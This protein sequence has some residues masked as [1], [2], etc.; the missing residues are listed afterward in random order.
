M[1]KIWKIFFDDS[2]ELREQLF[3]N[4]IMLG[5]LAGVFA[6][7]E[8]YFL[9]NLKQVVLPFILLF[10]VLVI[11]TYLTI[12]YH[13]IEITAIIVGGI[14][15]GIMFPVMFFKSGGIH[16]G[17]TVWFV[18]S[19]FY[20]FIM[21]NGFKLWLFL[22]ITIVVDLTCYIVGYHHPAMIT[23]LDSEYTIYLDSAFG[24]FAVGITGSLMMR[25]QMNMFR[26]EREI[27]KQQTK[28]L[29]RAGDY[30]NAFFANVSHEIRTPLNSIIGL[31]DMILRE[32]V[33]EKVREYVKNSDVASH[34]LLSM[35]N[36]FLDISQLELKKMSIL[37][38]DYATKKLL[39]N[40]IDVM[41]VLAQEKNLEF[42][43]DIDEELPSILLGD[44]KRV[45][46]IL[47]NLLSN[48]IKYTNAGSVT[49]TVTKEWVPHRVTPGEEGSPEAFEKSKELDNVRL[50]I[51]VQDTGIGIRS[52]DLGHIY[53]SFKRLDGKT[54][55]A[56]QG[57]GLGLFITKQLVD[58]M[59]GNIWVD[60]IYTK[61]STFTVEIEQQVVDKTPIYEENVNRSKAKESY[62]QIFEAPEARV[63]IVDDDHISRLVTKNLLQ[64]TKMN[65]EVAKNGTECLNMAK[66]KYYH[67]IIMDHML[68]DMNGA[69]ILMELRNQENGLCRD[70]AVLLV[71]ANNLSEARRIFQENRFDGYLEKPFTSNALEEEVLKLLPKEIIELHNMAYTDTVKMVSAQKR[72]RICITSDCVCEIPEEWVEKYDIRLMYLYIKTE[73][74]RFADTLEIHSN[75][76]SDYLTREMSTAQAVS[77]SIEEYEEFFA[78]RLTEA[79]EVI[80]ISMAANTG[81]SYS[82]A[83]DAATG[84]DHVHVIDSGQ[85]SGAQ[86]L[87]VMR[88]AEMA[89]EGLNTKEIIE[90]I[91]K[92]KSM[93]EN[94]FLM[95]S[96]RIYYQHGYISKF[97]AKLLLA[98]KARPMLGMRQ[99]KLS[100]MGFFIGSEDHARKEFVK[101]HLRL[102]KKIDH[103]VVFISHVGWTVKELNVLKQQ[104]LSRV[105]FENVI[106]E[107]ASV[108]NACNAG[109][110]TVGIA[111][112][113]RSDID[114]EHTL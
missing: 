84:F 16:G 78:D 69:E 77:A 75:Y 54:N 10:V 45:Q 20:I 70:S 105:P 103:R 94:R 15:T 74:G 104:I 81:I 50:K 19:I 57:T 48:A 17:A 89:M 24:V 58:L 76:L 107:N 87:L 63:L 39:D 60:S 111:F 6:L 38:S 52:E 36:D 29:E 109:L 80:H 106:I 41:K 21:F 25:T 67:V 5:S 56:T 1:N 40:M 101:Y 66:N 46:Q 98:I 2:L 4:I 28:E 64:H 30:K 49:F 108:S 86:G 32:D 102:K 44:L 9:G 92:A 62:Q 68:P 11:A 26:K 97:P 82:N 83:V 23:P 55:Q 71:T 37:K 47:L 96:S 65:I 59:D 12:Q 110:K 31:N 88:A 34:M 93:I 35:V 72:K 27:T 42:R 95:P 113:K 3:R 79:D 91:E 7:A 8:S 53:D 14:L 33:S 43:V 90:G 22:A 61:G 114:K 18:F 85:I 13:K 112:F 99:S 51:S 100:V 73:S